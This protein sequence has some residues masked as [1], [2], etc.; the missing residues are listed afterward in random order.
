[1]NENTFC[2]HHMQFSLQSKLS[3]LRHIYTRRSPKL[4]LN[5]C[6]G[7]SILTT[8]DLCSLWHP[9]IISQSS[10]LR[11]EQLCHKLSTKTF[12]TRSSIATTM[13]DFHP[14]NTKCPEKISLSSGFKTT[15]VWSLLSQSEIA[16]MEQNKTYFCI[17]I[18]ISSAASPSSARSHAYFMLIYSV[19]NHGYISYTVRKYG[20]FLVTFSL[21]SPKW[22][23]SAEC[24]LGRH[25]M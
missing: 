17:T 12:Q 10:P 6:N 5:K 9:L 24:C 20:M 11:H 19:C 4:I 14:E 13:H 25:A 3:K 18:Q 16:H 7:A 23:T 1:M 21:L 22:F 2:L 15:E 8:K